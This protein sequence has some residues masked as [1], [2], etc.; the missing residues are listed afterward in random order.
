[1]VEHPDYA[2]FRAVITLLA[3]Y[4]G[5][6]NGVLYRACTPAY[7]N[8]HDLLTGEGARKFGG[9]WNPP[10]SFP[11][12]YLA[13]SLEGAIAETLGVATHYGFD[14]AARLPMTL[15]A[16]DATLDRVLDLTDAACRKTL[17]LTL[18]SMRHGPWRDENAAGREAVT[19]AVG[20]AAHAAGLQGIRVPSSLKR[21]FRNL[22]V[23]PSN[24]GATGMLKIRSADKLPPPPTR[25][26]I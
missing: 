8:T 10:G 13:E 7:A 2:H 26:A 25:R 23:F 4:S 17:G 9:R 6:F 1:M 20:H 22:N 21:T 15:V 24:L 5:T 11:A 18:A 16:V 14:P 12:V 3:A 19:Q